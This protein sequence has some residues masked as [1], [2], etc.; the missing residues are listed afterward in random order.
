MPEARLLPHPGERHR[1]VNDITVRGTRIGERS[2]RLSFLVDGRPADLRLPNAGS[3]ERRDDLWR[4]TCFE[5]FVRVPGGYAEYNLSPS[6]DWAAY[7][8]TGYR[9]GMEPL[10]VAVPE[11]DQNG[12][13][14]WYEMVATL[15]LPAD[16]A[17][18]APLGLCAVIE[19]ADGTKSYWA[20]AHAPGPPDFH[21][22]ACFVATLPA[23]GRP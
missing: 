6:S 13:S 5:L 8:F 3:G 12:G 10:D 20:L 9:R 16:V 4:T 21:N 15:Q 7:R 18:D 14:A 2:L 22:P 11:I 19:A 23:P 17:E 1:F